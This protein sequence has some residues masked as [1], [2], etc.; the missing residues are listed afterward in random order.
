MLESIRVIQRQTIE[1]L[2]EAT[3]TIITTVDVTDPVTNITSQNDVELVENEPCRLSYKN[4]YVM[5]DSEIADTVKQII[6]LFIK[7]ELDIP[8]GSLFEITQHGKTSTYSNSGFP[9]IHGS[10][11]EIIL[12]L[13]DR[14]GR[15]DG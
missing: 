9:V 5:E 7:P 3:C 12:N 14:Y 10:H 1:A 15:L 13:D 4:D 8:A 11:Q 2:Y 6:K